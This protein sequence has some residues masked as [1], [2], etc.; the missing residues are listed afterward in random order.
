MPSKGILNDNGFFITPNGSFWDEDRNYF[1]HLGFDKHGGTYD[2]YGLYIP[3]KEKLVFRIFRW[4]AIIA[5][6][7]SIIYI[8][9][10]PYNSHFF[11]SI[12]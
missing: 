5:T 9:I 12:I 3:G 4:V 1:N 10:N 8:W 11:I 6:V 7:L 2:K